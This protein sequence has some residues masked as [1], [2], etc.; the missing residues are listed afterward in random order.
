MF[1]RVIQHIELMF[2]DINPQAVKY[3]PLTTSLLNQFHV[4]IGNITPDKIG[5]YEYVGPFEC[6]GKELILGNRWQLLENKIKK[7]VFIV[8]A[9][10]RM[11]QEC[12]KFFALTVQI[13]E[14]KNERLWE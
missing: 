12:K 6:V 1:F 10:V 4:F 2:S 8:T 11:R 7:F 14:D 5:Y 13:C 3:H 9:S